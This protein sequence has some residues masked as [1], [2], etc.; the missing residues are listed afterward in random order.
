MCAPSLTKCHSVCQSVDV[1][2]E[3]HVTV[4]IRGRVRWWWWEWRITSIEEVLLHIVLWTWQILNLYMYSYKIWHRHLSCTSM[5]HV[6][7]WHCIIHSPMAATQAGYRFPCSR[8][9]HLLPM[10]DSKVWWVMTWV[11][12]T[13]ETERSSSSQQTRTC[14]FPVQSH[15]CV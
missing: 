6:Y 13:K 11:V 4:W 12:G 2:R 3:V 9:L 8:T 1:G 10:L 15:T 5:L 14:L 7:T